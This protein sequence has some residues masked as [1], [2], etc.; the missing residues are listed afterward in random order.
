MQT[1]VIKVL[2][3]ERDELLGRREDFVE[4][5]KDART[6]VENANKSF[7]TLITNYLELVDKICAIND[8]LSLH[9]IS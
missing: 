8:E 6:R 2:E 7:N 9:G 4:S 3:T 1:L 5:I